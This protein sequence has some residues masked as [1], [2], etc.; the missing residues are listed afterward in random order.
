[1]SI[2]LYS[3]VASSYW[4]G[5]LPPVDTLQYRLHDTFT[6]NQAISLH[7]IDPINSNLSNYYKFTNLAAR[8]IYD[9]DFV[10]ASSLYDSAFLFKKSP[11]YVDLNNYILVNNKS[12]LHDKNDMAIRH[13]M[14]NKKMDT[15][16]LFIHTPKRVFNKKNLALIDKLANEQG[17]IKPR[18]SAFEESLREI[19]A[20]DQAVRDYSS[21]EKKDSVSWK[22]LYAKRDSV[23]A[24]NFIRFAGLIAQYGFPSEETF[25]AVF[26]DSRKWDAVISVLLLHFS[27]V[28]DEKV[29]K[30]VINIILE[31]LYAGKLHSSLFAT[32]LDIYD[33]ESGAQ[34]SGQYN[35][36]NTTLNLV[37]G[38]AYRPFVKYSDSLMRKI[39]TNRI[40][41]GLDSF[42]ITQ[43]QVACQF[44][45]S[46]ATEGSNLIPMVPYASIHQ[47]PAGFAKLS[48][49]ESNEDLSSYKI[50]ASKILDECSYQE[51]IY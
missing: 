50:N 32:L 34:M 38:E 12:K 15:T 43:K 46:L 37:L 21:I 30:R 22:I 4:K 14:V 16:Q 9:N 39:N 51:K 41:I 10:T 25:G 28:K 2:A 11:F 26:D 5:Y 33:L 36:M 40:A 47:L 3:Y 45:G 1:M 13:L 23:D 19:F 7:C 49:E 35:F 29:T 44:I 20:L 18:V 17:K 8:A 27:H 31:A 48:L 24:E 6:K 42:H